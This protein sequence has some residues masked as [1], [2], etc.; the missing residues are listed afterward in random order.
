MNAQLTSHGTALFNAN[1]TALE[2]DTAGHG[3][4]M[5]ANETALEDDTAWQTLTRDPGNSVG[6]NP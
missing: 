3:M 5:N 6:G 4:Q 2:D 1:E